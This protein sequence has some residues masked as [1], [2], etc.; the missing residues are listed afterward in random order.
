MMMASRS[1]PKFFLTGLRGGVTL[2]RK[3]SPRL[4]RRHIGRVPDRPLLI[5]LAD[6]FFMLPVSSRR[7]NQRAYE[8]G[9]G[10]ERSHARVNPAGKPRG[11]FL[12]HPTIAIGIAEQSSRAVSAALRIG[13][14]GGGVPRG[15]EGI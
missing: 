10:T 3:F 12:K 15:I 11:N 14:T 5:S 13:T 4:L 1:R 9:Y 2:L 7:A 8:I 6:A